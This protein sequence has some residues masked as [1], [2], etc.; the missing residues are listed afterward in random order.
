MTSKTAKDVAAEAR[1]VADVLDSLPPECPLPTHVN[2]YMHDSGPEIGWLLFDTPGL[3]QA[4]LAREIVHVIGGRW[5]KA[6][7][8]YFN[9]TQTRGAVE[10]S[11]V[12]NREA[13]CRRVVTGVETVTKII[14]DPDAPL[15]EVTEEVEQ[16]EWECLPL[17]GAVTA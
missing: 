15:V 14:P 7:R 16:V 9:F 10:L 11:V 3:D 13:V 1:M 4:A 12:V 2:I 17:L 6:D 5:E 8:G